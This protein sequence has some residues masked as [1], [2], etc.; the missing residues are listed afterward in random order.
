MKRQLFI[1]LTL[2]LSLAVAG[3]ARTNWSGES[4]N[5]IQ[6]Q[7]QEQD[8]EQ[9]QNQKPGPKDIQENPRI[10]KH[11]YRTKDLEY[12]QID[13]MVNRNAQEKMNQKLQTYVRKVYSDRIKILS[14]Y[15]KD[16]KEFEPDAGAEL[17]PY[18]S[19]LN[20]EV[21]YLSSEKISL[22]LIND[23]GT[24]GVHGN[25]QG[26]V[27]NFNV[28]TGKEVPLEDNF[29]SEKY[30]SQARHFAIS[31]LA[32]HP[33]KY[34]L[35]DSK[36]FGPDDI[37]SYYW[38]KEGMDFL[39]PPYA[40]APYAA[41]F[42]S[43]PI[44]DYLMDS[45][46][47]R[48]LDEVNNKQKLIAAQPSFS[49]YQGNWAQSVGPVEQVAVN[50]TFS[51]GMPAT[52]NINA[53]FGDEATTTGDMYVLFDKNGKAKADFTSKS[54]TAAMDAI[55]EPKNGKAVIT[56]NNDTI[57]VTVS[58]PAGGEDG[59]LKAGTYHLEKK[60]AETQDIIY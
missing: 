33:D 7:K 11:H 53:M 14:Q 19:T 26:T 37:T 3:C 54:Y 60:S 17:P 57:T 5:H 16:K 41:G 50:L 35:Y 4:V 2:A 23:I 36:S 43:L 56:L 47:Y 39:F 30:L 24:G 6:E 34:R 42:V 12:P 55:G 52:V 25:P 29:S 32:A 22:L 45:P 58:Y 13:G 44:P 18:Y 8:Y 21:K 49:S 15:E 9:K 31:Y 51:E 59:K 28:K 27:F 48:S 20:Y 38:T 40:V 1:A 46:D 10:E